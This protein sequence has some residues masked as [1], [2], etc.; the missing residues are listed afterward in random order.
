[1]RLCVRLCTVQ[2]YLS[3]L[4][5]YNEIIQVA[6]NGCLK[7]LEELV[8]THETLVM[9]FIVEYEILVKTF[10]VGVHC[11]PD[12]Y[13]R[14]TSITYPKLHG[15]AHLVDALIQLGHPWG[16]NTGMCLLFGCCTDN[17]SELASECIDAVLVMCCRCMGD[18]PT[19]S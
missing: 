14:I 7:T 11:M 3:L 12:T 6:T 9:R 18:G 15:L 17:K 5:L 4:A 16:F 8:T 1:M 10:V 19:A 13:S 2:S